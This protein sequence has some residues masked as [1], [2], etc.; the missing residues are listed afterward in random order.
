MKE[1][2]NEVQEIEKMYSRNIRNVFRST[3]NFLKKF[4]RFL[5]DQTLNINVSSVNVHGG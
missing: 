5:V 2:A 3:C 4:H 1:H